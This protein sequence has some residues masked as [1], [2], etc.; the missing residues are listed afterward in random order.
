VT[1][2]RATTL[3]ARRE[4]SERVRSRAVQISTVLTVVLVAAIAILAGV[5]GDD[6]PTDYDVGAQGAESVAIAEAARAAGSAFDSSVTVRRFDSAG[7][8]RAAVRDEDVDAAL[9]DGVIVTRDDSQDELEQLLQ[10]AAR[11]V[12][13]GEA[14]R[15]EGLSEAETRRALD[16]PPLRATRLDGQ[17]DGGSEG[18]AFAAALILYMQLIVYGLAVAS[19]VVEEKASRVVEVLLAAIPPRA[20]LAG[21]VAGIGLLGLIQLLLTAAAGLGVAAASGA[22]ELDGR[23]A[24]TL[25]VVLGWFLLGYLLWASLFAV[26]GAVVSRQEDLQSST[27]VL[28]VLLVVCYL[29]SFPVLE[30]PDSALAVVTSLVPFSSPIVM[31]VRMAAG[32]VGAAEIAASLALLAVA[33]AVVIP[34]GARI[35]ENAVLRMGK[36]LK[37]REAW[38]ARPLAR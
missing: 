32:E 4:F 5:L 37:L 21:K 16:P 27:T 11:Q 22:I 26:A 25:A 1:F 9:V 36:P 20:L 7:A 3:V 35:Y 15:T 18:L 30:E 31:P 13:A 8:A 28:T 14:L 12:R 33:I 17:D 6:G 29:V 24:G 23:D 19:G 10:A 34:I 2:R 38:S